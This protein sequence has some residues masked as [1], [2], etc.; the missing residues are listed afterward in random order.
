MSKIQSLTWHFTVITVLVSGCIWEA[1]PSTLWL[2]VGYGGGI[3]FHENFDPKWS[4]TQN[5]PGSATYQAFSERCTKKCHILTYFDVFWGEKCWSTMGFGASNYS[6]DAAPSRNPPFQAA[7]TFSVVKRLKMGISQSI[8]WLR[9]GFRLYPF[10]AVQHHDSWV[11]F[12]VV[13]YVMTGQKLA[14]YT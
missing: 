12:W 9:S 8:W 4:D 11:C 1:K 7:W 5:F 6:E 14:K 13:H 10:Q 3:P 2:R